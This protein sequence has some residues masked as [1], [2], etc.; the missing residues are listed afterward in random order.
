MNVKKMGE[1][2]KKKR[3]EKGLT[4]KELAEQLFITDRAISK[5]ERGLSCPDI[6]LLQELARILDT[7][8]V[9]LL[10]GET[11]K[12]KKS[13]SEQ[14]VISSMKLSQDSILE[15]IKFITNVLTSIIVAIFVFFILITNFR[16]I[17]LGVKKYDMNFYDYG[18]ISYP[19]GE[20]IKKDSTYDKEIPKKNMD[21]TEVI[22]N[23]QGKYTEEEYQKIWNNTKIMR[24]R[25]SEQENEK[26]YQIT[27]YTYIDIVNFY[28]QHQNIMTIEVNL[29]ELYQIL[30]KYDQSMVDHYIRYLEIKDT[31]LQEWNEISRFLGQ[32]YYIGTFYRYDY[33]NTYGIMDS[34]YE[35]EIMLCDD[36][37]KVGELGES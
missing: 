6:S 8:V 25:I 35:K 4:Q 5:W 22:L 19:G 20:Y 21:K 7:S 36:I 10:K 1:F 33:P 17:Y 16:S 3:K 23:H 14:D 11:I 30:I 29:E 32:P 13:I 37:M 9:E 31:V 2:I 34:I 12:N 28:I 27:N 26:Y 24:E 18:G 15:K